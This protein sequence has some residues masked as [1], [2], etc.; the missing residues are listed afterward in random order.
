M[1]KQVTSRVIV[2]LRNLRVK[3]QNQNLKLLAKSWA[4]KPF[5]LQWQN[6]INED[7]LGP[8]FVSI[9]PERRINV[10]FKKLE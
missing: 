9:S 2:E 6:S 3:I 7:F 1:S 8:G 4:A 5:K 10:V